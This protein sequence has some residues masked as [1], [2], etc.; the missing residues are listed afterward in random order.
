MS[1]VVGPALREQI[2]GSGVR[3]ANELWR[4]LGLKAATANQPQAGSPPLPKAA[5]AVTARLPL[6]D[7]APISGNGQAPPS[8]AEASLSLSP[9]ELLVDA[10]R[11]T[12]M[13]LQAVNLREL[14]PSQWATLR[15][16]FNPIVFSYDRGRTR[17]SIRNFAPASK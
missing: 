11:E 9:F 7:L 16:W 2:I 13:R 6:P 3:S 8:R 17:A 15:R 5:A 14:S 1:A 10:L 12:Q 4:L